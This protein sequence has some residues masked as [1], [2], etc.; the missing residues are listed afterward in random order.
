MKAFDYYKINLLNVKKYFYT[1][2]RRLAHRNVELTVNISSHI[3][4][5]QCK[6]YFTKTNRVYYE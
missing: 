2:K 4:S 3:C 6:S 1:Q 5:F